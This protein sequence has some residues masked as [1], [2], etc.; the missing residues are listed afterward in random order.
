MVEIDEKSSVNAGNGSNNSSEDA[1]IEKNGSKKQLTHPPLLLASYALPITTFSSYMYSL[2]RI[3]IFGFQPGV[4]L[5][6]WALAATFGVPS[7][8]SAVWRLCSF[9]ASDFVHIRDS[10]LRWDYAAGL[11]L[12][13]PSN[14]AGCFVF[15]KRLVAELLTST[16]CPRS[17]NSC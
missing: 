17:L 2:A 3:G 7:A 8:L 13:G 11:R 14:V 9:F 10:F 12:L 1:S 4:R 15:A 5:S 6:P 16:F